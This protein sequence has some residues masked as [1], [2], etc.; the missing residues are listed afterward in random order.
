MLNQV[1][2]IGRLGS[3]PE[4]RKTQSGKSVCSFSLATTDGYG[5]SQRTEWHRVVAWEKAAEF[6]AQYAD[7][8][9]LVSI[10]GR[11]QTR[12]YERDG[13]KHKVTEIIANSVQLLDS[14]PKQDKPSQPRQEQKPRKQG[15][16]RGDYRPTGYDDDDVP[17]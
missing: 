11:L 5:E 12:E 7:S 8:G 14:K 16:S 15:A 9:R 6:L 17:Y 3:T 1:N 2:L 13:Q 4:L 10:V